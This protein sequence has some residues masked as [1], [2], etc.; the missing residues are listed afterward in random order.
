[1]EFFEAVAKRRSIRKYS[2]TPVPDQVVEKALD[3]AIK[4][5]NSSNLQ[6]WEFYWVQSPEK[7][8]ALIEACFSQNAAATAQQF[9]VFVSR[10]DTWKRNRDVL[11]EQLKSQGEVKSYMKDYYYKAIP[12]SYVTEP[13]GVLGFIKKT[14]ACVLGIS[15][16]V[17]RGPAYRSELYEVVTK[18]C[19]LACENFMLAISA[20]GFDSCPMEGFDAVR[21]QKVLNLKGLFHVVMVISVGE[22][23]PSTPNIPQFRVPK[24]LVIFKV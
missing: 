22:K 6:A 23:D 19:A 16:P 20:Q 12:L 21:V 8:Q 10:I 9:V 18:S 24:D 4:A 15:K 7:K 14:I 3:A 1:M 5:P 13:T 2:K 17:P 11:M